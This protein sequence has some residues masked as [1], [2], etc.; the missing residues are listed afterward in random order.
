MMCLLIHSHQGSTPA[1]LSLPVYSGSFTPFGHLQSQCRKAFGCLS[2]SSR[3]VDESSEIF[4]DAALELS[5][6]SMSVFCRKLVCQKNSMMRL[7]N[8]LIDKFAQKHGISPGEV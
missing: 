3:Y 2:V 8:D 6:G 5:D 4:Y 7:W 1:R